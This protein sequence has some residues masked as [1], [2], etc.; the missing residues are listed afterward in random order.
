MTEQ[1]RI[2]IH[3]SGNKTTQL[4]C[5]WCGLPH[6][7]EPA[8][9]QEILNRGDR[10]IQENNLVGQLTPEETWT[11][12]ACYLF[13]HNLPALRTECNH[14]VPRERIYGKGG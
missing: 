10:I 14:T 3:E 8:Y 9:R 11:C 7:V 5:N 2:H 13:L 12:G 6:D 4:T 1:V